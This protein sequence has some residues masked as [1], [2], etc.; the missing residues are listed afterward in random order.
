MAAADPRRW[1]VVD[2]VGTP[3]DVAEAVARAVEAA[4][5]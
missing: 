1:V 4:L 5:G 2:G 3:E